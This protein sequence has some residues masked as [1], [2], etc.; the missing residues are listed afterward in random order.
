MGDDARGLATPVPRC[1]LAW[2]D[3]RTQRL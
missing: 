3:R 2:G 1:P